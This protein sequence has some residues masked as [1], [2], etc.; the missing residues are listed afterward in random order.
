[1]DVAFDTAQVD[2]P[3]RLPAWRELVNRVFLPLD[4]AP[5]AAAA[6]QPGAF[7]AAVTGSDRGELRVWRVRATPLSAVRAV[8]HI[9]SS[10][11]DDYLLGLHVSGTAVAAQDDRQVTLG[12]GDFALFDSARPYRIAFRGPGVF[13]HVIFQVPRASLEARSRAVGTQTALRVPAASRAGRLASPYLRTLAQD[14]PPAQAFIDTGLDL[15]ASALRATARPDPGRPAPAGELKRYA[16]AHLGDPALSPKAVARAGYLSV[17]QLHRLFAL[18]GVSFGAWLLEQRLRRCRDDLA[19]TQLS[20]QS[21]AEVAARWGFRS[22]AH[23]TR[24]FHARYGITPGE[25]RR[26]ARR[27]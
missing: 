17:R 19:D 22:P 20:R 5:L 6:G 18:E 27:P 24:A 12:P 3:E 16:L 9:R 26:A 13:E 11:C 4:I 10:G 15:A 1:M 7:G 23:F 21:V 14:E 25:L 2:P 8:R